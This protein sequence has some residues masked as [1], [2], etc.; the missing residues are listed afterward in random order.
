MSIYGIRF[1]LLS[2]SLVFWSKSI[3]QSF[4]FAASEKGDETKVDTNYVKVFP[5]LV[6]GRFYLSRKYTDLDM[7]DEEYGID[8]RYVP[9]TTL[10]LG[11]G[12]TYHG[13]SLNLAYGFGFLNPDE[14]QGETRYLDLQSHVYKRKT[15]VD[16][17]GQF[18]NGLYLENTSA[19]LPKFEDAFYVRPD[20]R[21]R[22]FGFS[23][24]HL[25]KGDRYSFSASFIQDEIQ[26][27]STGSFLLGGEIALVYADTDS[28]MVAPLGIDS[29]FTG[30]RGLN[31][32]GFFDIGPKGGYT[33]T[34]VLWDHFF[35]TGALFLR[36]AI[37]PG[38]YRYE[39]GEVIE[40]WLL[41]PSASG[42]FALGYNSEEFY[43]GISVVSSTFSTA[44]ERG[45]EI[46]SFG[47]GNVR[48]N[49]AKRFYI[50]KK[51]RNNLEKLPVVPN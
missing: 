45:N 25:F 19:V 46:A 38:R 10:N 51:W 23:Y 29:A 33:H 37:G 16:F 24:L 26:K 2:V 50:S 7:R 18:Y 8:L 11:V 43:L 4:E 47:V 9:N 6:T 36:L 34:F 32:I 27:K 41:N 49:F 22:L 28:S 42:R 15:V 3:G 17:Y 40:R 5:D 20:M 35:I 1:L 44:L 14:G 48:I 39:D 13:F 12:A 31:E 21:I 30:F